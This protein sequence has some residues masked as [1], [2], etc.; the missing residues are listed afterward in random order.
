MLLERL[1]HALRTGEWWVPAWWQDSRYFESEHADRGEVERAFYALQQV[2]DGEWFL[3]QTTSYPAPPPS[4]PVANLHHGD[5]PI[6]DHEHLASAQ[7]YNSDEKMALEQ[8]FCFG[9]LLGIV[10]RTKGVL[11]LDIVVRIACF[12]L[13]GFWLCV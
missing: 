6:T 9:Q 4:H 7:I 13:G 12:F 10:L 5:A 1:K 2:F 8:C 3:D 11:D